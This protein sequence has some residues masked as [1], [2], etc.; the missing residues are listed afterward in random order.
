MNHEKESELQFI[1]DFVADAC[2]EN[3]ICCDQLRSLWTAY[4]LR[5]DLIVDTY[6][7]DQSIM[8]I[9]NVIEDAGGGGE[10]DT[11]FWS[12]FD[13]FDDFMCAYLV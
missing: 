8:D 10:Q 5:H 6:E 9:W 13:S 12:N 11:A 3:D 1:R 4:C 2:F 7:Y